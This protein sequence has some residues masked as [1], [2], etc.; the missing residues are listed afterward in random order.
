MRCG[1]RADVIA[2]AGAVQC[3][4]TLTIASSVPTCAG[5]VADCEFNSLLNAASSW[6]RRPSGRGSRSSWRW[7]SLDPLVSAAPSEG[8]LSVCRCRVPAWGRCGRR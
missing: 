7:G 4:S 6:R 5:I 1:A 2:L 3:A 8:D